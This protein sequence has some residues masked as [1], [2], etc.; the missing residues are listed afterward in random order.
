MFLGSCVH[1]QSDA[2]VYLLLRF[3]SFGDCFLDWRGYHRTF[4]AATFLPLRFGLVVLL[5]LAEL[6]VETLKFHSLHS[7]CF[8][9]QV[10]KKEEQKNR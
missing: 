3:R 8:L 5:Q 4:F 7:G 1:V 10:A 6:Q 2:S 9:N